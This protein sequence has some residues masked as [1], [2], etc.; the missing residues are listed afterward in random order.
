MESCRTDGYVSI[1]PLMSMESTTLFHSG[2]AHRSVNADVYRGYY[3]PAGMFRM[4]LSYLSL[5]ISSAQARPSLVMLGEYQL[6]NI[7]ASD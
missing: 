7:K 3:I 5:F 4:C 1:G 2:V 6:H